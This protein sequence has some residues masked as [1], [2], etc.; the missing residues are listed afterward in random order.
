[1]C[2]NH[3][4]EVVSRLDIYIPKGELPSFGE[5]VYELS[6]DMKR[7]SRSNRVVCEV[8]R[9]YGDNSGLRGRE[10]AACQ[11][12]VYPSG[13]VSEVHHERSVSYIRMIHDGYP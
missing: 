12:E 10:Y 6:R 8:T 1:M 9:C 7:L 4:G 11:R 13:C 3:R 5:R 2:H